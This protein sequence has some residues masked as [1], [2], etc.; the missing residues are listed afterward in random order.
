MYQECGEVGPIL[1]FVTVAKT[2]EMGAPQ[3]QRLMVRSHMLITVYCSIQLII[4][5]GNSGL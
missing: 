3:V 4:T 2:T 1:R 5:P